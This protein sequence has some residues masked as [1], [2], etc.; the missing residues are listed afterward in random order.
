MQLQILVM[1]SVSQSV[2]ALGR[3]FVLALTVVAFADEDEAKTPPSLSVELAS[4]WVMT[5]L[6][7]IY[8][9]SCY[10]DLVDLLLKLL[11]LPLGTAVPAKTNPP[12]GLELVM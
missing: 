10:N 1:W 3:T 9:R 11:A 2:S 6:T 12:M 5:E 8:E 4:G 7:R